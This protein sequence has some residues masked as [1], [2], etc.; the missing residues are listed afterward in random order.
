ML[1]KQMNQTLNMK[2]N[3]KFIRIL[4]KIEQPNI[5]RNDLIKMAKIEFSLSIEQAAGL[6]N[7]GIFLLK[8]H[9][10]VYAE[11][12]SKARN[13]I[14]SL[15]LLKQ[16]QG[17]HFV[18]S[19]EY[20]DAEKSLL[21]EELSI[22]RYEFDAYDEMR[23]VFPHKLIQIKDLQELATLRMH[24]LNGKIRAINKMIAGL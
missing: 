16:I 10:L 21:E 17:E 9:D 24:K 3:N 4:S 5:G 11:G 19:N 18:N 13:Y 22:T 6:I 7:R 1:L 2:L 8:K 12:G 15:K 20:L 14:F 23:K